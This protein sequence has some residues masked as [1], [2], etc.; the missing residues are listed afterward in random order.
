MD[1]KKSPAL[2][3]IGDVGVDVVLGPI[4]RWPAVGTETVMERSEL[5]TAV[6]WEALSR[7]K[8]SYCLKSAMLPS[9]L[10]GQTRMGD[11][12]RSKSRND[13]AATL[14]R[15]GSRVPFIAG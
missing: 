5:S 10:S 13:G 4:D 8:S 3:V 6:I 2:T 11:G 9:A 1:N 12:G 14:R 15:F 7:R